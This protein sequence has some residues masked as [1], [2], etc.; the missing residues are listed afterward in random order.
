MQ[1]KMR[2]EAHSA[3]PSVTVV[4]SPVFREIWWEAMGEGAALE[5]F[6]YRLSSPE[7]GAHMV[8]GFRIMDFLLAI[9]VCC[10]WGVGLSL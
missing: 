5:P 6:L 3:V 8:A 1:K 2:I 4:F 10:V 9:S 7:R